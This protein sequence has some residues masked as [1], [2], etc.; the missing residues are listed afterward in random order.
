MIG[1]LAWMLVLGACGM[2]FG[3]VWIILPLFAVAYLAILVAS[4]RGRMMR[5]LTVLSFM[6]LSGLGIVAAAGVTDRTSGYN[7]VVVERHG[8]LHFG[9]WDGGPITYDLGTLGFRFVLFRPVRGGDTDWLLTLPYWPFFIVAAIL[10]VVHTIG[11][12][13]L[14]RDVYRYKRGLCLECGY[15]LRASKDRCPEC[16]TPVI[17]TESKA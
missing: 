10:P 14:R 13:R 9:N 6:W 11:C 2:P 17:A 15:D 12:A 8:W 7:F 3:S 5:A 1:A 16:G 4:R